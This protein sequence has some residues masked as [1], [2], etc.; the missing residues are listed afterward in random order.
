MLAIQARRVVATRTPP[1]AAARLAVPPIAAVPLYLPGP[2]PLDVGVLLPAAHLAQECGQGALLLALCLYKI[3]RCVGSFAKALL[4]LCCAAI[5]IPIACAALDALIASARM[6]L[7]H[8][9]SAPS[10]VVIAEHEQ[11]PVVG[12]TL[13]SPAA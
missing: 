9:S 6:A 1:L 4:P 11:V 7:V 10:P 3:A 5:C 2:T 12:L 8:A 13:S